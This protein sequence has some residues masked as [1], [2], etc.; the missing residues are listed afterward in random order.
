MKKNDQLQLEHT[1]RNNFLIWSTYDWSKFGAEWI[2]SPLWKRSFIDFVLLKHLKKDSA[3]LEIGP[4]AGEWTKELIPRASRLIIVDLVPRCIEICKERFINFSNI[5][6]HVNDGESLD[7]LQDNSIDFVFSMN[8]FIQMSPSVMEQYFR[9]ISQ[10][11]KTN[12]IGFIHHSKNG[13]KKLGWRSEVTD[14]MVKEYCNR[15]RLEV[16]D[17]ITSWENGKY[18]IWANQI[19]DSI[20]IFKKS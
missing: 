15:Y 12:G 13:R 10:K 17:Q 16:I 8:V 6:Y 3:I 20:T 1:I 4:G 9:Q 19:I 7:F 11:L 14:M 5:D 18:E 2:P